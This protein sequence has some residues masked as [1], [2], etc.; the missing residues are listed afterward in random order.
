M[1]GVIGTGTVRPK[2]RLGGFVRQR[3]L[4]LG[5]T[6]QQLAERAGWTTF[7]T[8]GKIE[9]GESVF[10]MPKTIRRLAKALECDKGLLVRRLETRRLRPTTKLA[11]FVRR[12]CMELGLF[13]QD[14]G[15]RMY[16][17]DSRATHVTTEMAARLA[18]VLRLSVSDLR[19]FTVLRGANKEIASSSRIGRMI[20]ARRKELE[21]S[22]SALAERLGVSR[23]Y[24]SWI[25]REALNLTDA[26]VRRFAVAL[27]MNPKKLLAVLG[28]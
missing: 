23:A 18:T 19:P 9:R 8:C 22:G 12:R 1:A 24:V 5:L 7:H 6:Q 27:E 4:A 2:T 21:L 3:R 25:E 17:L 26:S 10:L 20:R 15:P 13:V 11:N 16:F 28:R 14:F